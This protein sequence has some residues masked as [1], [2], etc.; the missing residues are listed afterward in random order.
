MG[1]TGPQ[2]P[3][4]AA[5]ATGATGATGP[6]GLVWSGTWN[7]STQYALN[8]AVG[9]N[10]STY[11]SL[12]ANN[13][14]NTP[15]NA[16][17]EWSLVASAGATGST[18]ATGPAG[19]TGSQGATGATGSTGAT[20]PAGPTGAT[21]PQGPQGVPGIS[22]LYFTAPNSNGTPI[23]I[24]GNN[25][26]YTMATL[27]LPAGNY[28]ISSRIVAANDGAADVE[29]VCEIAGSNITTT[30]AQA[31]LLPDNNTVGIWLATLPIQVVASLPGSTAV[32]LQCEAAPGPLTL[33]MYYPQITAIPVTTLTQQ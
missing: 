18:G 1:L 31:D 17:T 4:G 7:N 24:T 33:F 29:V 9:Y 6:Q 15:G 22:N 20:G 27:T 19:P 23:T 2:G 32:T 5:G 3:Q 28:L 11:I 12:A 16:P 26:F 8:D 25:A 30:Y 21:G 10:G 13:T 14:G